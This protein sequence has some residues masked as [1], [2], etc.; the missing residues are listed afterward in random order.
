MGAWDLI[1]AIKEGR[2]KLEELKDEELPEEMQKMNPEER[3]V[4]LEQKQKEREVIQQQ[5]TE[6]AKKRE[7]YVQEE[8]K[9][10]ND[11]D[12]FD[13]VIL[14]TLREQAKKKGFEFE[15]SK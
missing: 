11:K 13:Q 4:Y 6:L 9:K 5:I 3:K 1:D 15:E 14:K 8:M 2:T 10:L 7:A 12:A